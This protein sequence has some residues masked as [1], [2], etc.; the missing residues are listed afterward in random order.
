VL[1][2]FLESSYCILLFIIVFNF[3]VFNFLV[4]NF[5][6]FNFFEIGIDYVIFRFGRSRLLRACCFSSSLLPAG[7]PPGMPADTWLPQAYGKPET[8]LRSAV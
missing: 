2:G 8:T 1:A 6:V 7:R 5:F 4:F 3:F